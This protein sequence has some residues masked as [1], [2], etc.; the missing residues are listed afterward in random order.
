M[1]SER[2]VN[3]KL[4][5]FKKRLKQRD[6]ADELEFSESY[7]SL[8]INGKRRSVKFDTWLKENI[9]VN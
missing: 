3:I 9:G 2:I 8:L 4:K 6:V 5:L 7:V 1:C